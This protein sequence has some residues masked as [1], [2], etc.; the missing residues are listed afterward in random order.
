MEMRIRVGLRSAG[1]LGS[2]LFVQNPLP[3]LHATTTHDALTY[4]ENGFSK[5]YRA[6]ATTDPLLSSLLQT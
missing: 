5:R 2:F 4:F 3:I 1:L 6:R